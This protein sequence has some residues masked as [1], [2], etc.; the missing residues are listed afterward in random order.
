[1]LN[2][3]IIVGILLIPYLIILRGAIAF[4]NIDTRLGLFWCI[5]ITTILYVLGLLMLYGGLF[6]I[7]GNG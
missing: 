5:I 6:F 2:T 1:M 3:L 4:Y 7:E